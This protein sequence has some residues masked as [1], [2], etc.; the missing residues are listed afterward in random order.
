M[1]EDPRAGP[2]VARPGAVTRWGFLS[3]RGPVGDH[4]EPAD[5]REARTGPRDGVLAYSEG[6]AG[7]AWAFGLFI[8]AMLTDLADGIIARR[9][10][11]SSLL[12]L[13]LDPV[14]DKIV[15]LTMFFVLADLG[16]I[17]FWMAVLMMAR[18]FL[19]GGLRSAAASAGQVVGANF[20]G[21]T[22]AWLQTVCISLGL[23]VRAFGVGRAIEGPMV[24]WP[25][26]LTLL[27][28][29]VF[30]GVFLWWNRALLKPR[31]D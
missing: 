4:T 28:A 21:R 11:Q 7:R 18:E 3:T 24:T 2:A 14:T 16:L 27:L 10:G 25:T 22:K 15:L 5:L 26:G 17:P 12:G 31:G 13:Y 19:V 6:M 8:F 20:M 29:W 9:P 1:Q 30:A 23:G